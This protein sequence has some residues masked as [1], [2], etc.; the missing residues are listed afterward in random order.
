MS[1][2]VGIVG[3]S[4]WTDAMYLP[5]LSNHP[6]VE[7]VAICGRNQERAAQ[8]AHTWSIPNAYSDY[9]RMIEQEK[10]NALFVLSGNDSH[11]AI[12]MAGLNAGLHVLCEK[13]LGLN[14]LQAMEM[15]SLA[16]AKQVKQMVPFT[17]RFMPTNRYIKELLNEGYLGQPY[18]LNLRYYTGFGRQPGYNWRF[19]QSK[20]GS[21]AIGDIGSHFLYLAM[22]WFGE[23]VEI[24][25][26]S[27]FLSSRPAHNPEG[28]P[29]TQSEDGAIMTLI[30]ANG[31]HGVVHATTM[32]Y[33]ETPFG[34]THHAELHGSD[35]T[36]YG[37][38]DWDKI[39]TV[40]GAKVGEGIIQELI[41]PAHIWGSARQ[42]TVH[43]TYR[44]IFRQQDHM[45]RGFINSIRDDTP[46][47]PNFADGAAVQRLID[48]AMLSDKE[49]RRVRVA[50][51]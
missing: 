6:D 12:T 27:S 37:F 11:Y 1:V 22:W 24:S 26:Q 40:R 7:I 29:Y 31:A 5:A 35:G 50:E 34:Q 21:G 3:T 41:L 51:I 38:I 30:F 9:T 2:A 47:T 44:D 42:D 17:Y 16:E 39:Q 10:L 33:E 36:L 8:M 18:H 25:C 13:P 23:I 19:D 32:A 48:A 45:A 46:S 4:W 43:N 14:Y 20:A 15:A 49:R 28:H